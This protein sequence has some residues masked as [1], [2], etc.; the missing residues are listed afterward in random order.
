MKSGDFRRVRTH[1]ARLQA[2]TGPNDPGMSAPG[3]LEAGEV[4]QIASFL[5]DDLSIRDYYVTA[6][7]A[8]DI[9]LGIVHPTVVDAFDAATLTHRNHTITVDVET[10]AGIT[11]DPATASMAI[12]DVTIAVRDQA[13]QSDTPAD[14]HTAANAV[15][16]LDD[17]GTG[18][19]FTDNFAAVLSAIDAVCV[20][21]DEDDCAEANRESETELE[22]VAT[23]DAVGA[24]SDPFERV[25]FWV[26]DVNG[27][28]WLLGSDTSGESDRV[29][30]TNRARTWTYS[31][32]ASAADL[33]ML[34]REAA[35]PPGSDSDSHTVR[36]FGVNDDGVAYAL[37][38]TVTID[39]GETDQ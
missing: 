38:G 23:A 30:S 34:T 28:S 2:A 35:F 17:P 7:F 15:L 37:S 36:A 21:E 22:V 10:Y 13:Q 31:L 12:E 24:F 11:T 16:T 27:A 6:N 26:Q 4:F 32:D 25:D 33:Y 18:D 19:N 29:S 14:R 9:D 20:A 3:S 39:D 1:R 8:G 5:N